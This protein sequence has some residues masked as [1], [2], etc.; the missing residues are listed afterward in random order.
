MSGVEIGSGIQIGSGITIGDVV[1]YSI[2]FVTEDDAY[3]FITEDGQTL[4]EEQ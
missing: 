1:A 4:I 3:Y 2:E